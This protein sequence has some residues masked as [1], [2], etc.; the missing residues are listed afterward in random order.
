MEGSMSWNYLMSTVWDMRAAIAPK[1]GAIYSFDLA[2]PHI[3]IFCAQESHASDPWLIGMLEVNWPFHEQSGEVVWTFAESYI[4]GDG[5]RLSLPNRNP[6]ALLVGNK[7]YD[8]KAN[9]VMDESTRV[10]GRGRHSLE[11]GE[12][13]LR[14]SFRS[15]SIQKPATALYSAGMKEASLSM[16]SEAVKRSK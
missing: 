14:S 1:H 16:F 4:S 11:C 12:C 7:V 9:P 2:L 5:S 15:E 10:S 3:G 8:S 6:M 13:G